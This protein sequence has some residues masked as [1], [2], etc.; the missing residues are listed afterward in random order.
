MREEIFGPVLPIVIVDSE[1]EAIELANDSEFG[2]GASVWTRDRAEGRADRAPDRVGDGL[3]Q[4]PLLHPRRL[5][6]LV[7]RRQGLRPRPLALQV[8]LLRV[9]QHQARHLGAGPDAATSG[10]TP[11]TRRSARRSAPR[12]GC[13]TASG[14]D[15][16]Q[17]PARGRRCRCSRSARRRCASAA[18]DR[19]RDRGRRAAA[20]LRRA[21]GARRRQLRA[22]RGRDAASCSGPTAPARRRCCGCSRRCCGPSGGE[23][24]VLGCAASRRG[25]EGCA[26]GSA[27]SAT[28]R[29]ST[30]TSPGARTC[31]S[32]PA[33]TGSTATPPRRGSTS[34]LGRDRDGAARRRAGRRRSRPG[35]RSGSRSA[36]ASCTSP[37]C[38]CSTSPT[39]TSTP[40]GASSSRR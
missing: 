19:T 39:R 13:S 2:L 37:S 15:P 40:R 33:C 32:T 35:W 36:A 22:G 29:C 17:G 24:R 4:R 9:R 38:C 8:R 16:D 21:D 10:G 18:L 31:A 26:G 5:P 34:L 30:A 1:E 28:S 14:A 27:T 20:R 25:L 23:A 6:V 11:T 12:R 7:G 3:D